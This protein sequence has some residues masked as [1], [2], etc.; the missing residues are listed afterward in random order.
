MEAIV[1]AGGF[2]TRLAGVVKDVPKPMAPVCGRPFLEYVLGALLREGIDHIVLAVGYKK[3]CIIEQ[4]GSTFL[5]VPIDYSVEEQPLYTGGAIKRALG[6]C[7]DERVFAVNGDTFFPV[8]LQ[9]MR[10]FATEKHTP[11]VIAVKQ[12][13]DFSRYGTVRFDSAQYVISFQEKCFCREGFINGGVYDMERSVLEHFPSAFS[14]EKDCLP[15][16]AEQRRL[17]AFCDDADFIDIGIPEDYRAAQ[18]M[19]QEVLP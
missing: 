1:L 18:T 12:M 17:Q 9:A 4:F 7:R 15:Q 16:L 13:K 3:E 11:A 10:R 14:L 6:L 19:F 5:G 2:G 8:Q